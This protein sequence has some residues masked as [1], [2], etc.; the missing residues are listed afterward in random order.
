[1]AGGT[2]ANAIGEECLVSPLNI[3]AKC[4]ICT[5]ER[6][7]TNHWFL[8]RV[9]SSRARRRSLSLLSYS[10]AEAQRGGD[11]LCGEECVHKW[12][13][14]HLVGLGQG[15]TTGEK[16]GDRQTNSLDTA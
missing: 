5:R 1:M 9:S 2:V 14:Q 12:L 8:G 16:S 11:I 4:E 10:L 6:L 3:T 13:A 7:G 15:S